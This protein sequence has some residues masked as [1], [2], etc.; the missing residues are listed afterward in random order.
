MN[1]AEYNNTEKNI[2]I[3][4]GK[5]RI[6]STA[7]PKCLHTFV[8]DNGKV[9]NESIMYIKYQILT[10]YLVYIMLDYLVHLV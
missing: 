5:I 9:P 3:L 10:R 8:V 7:W 4:F 2:I 6:D 1:H